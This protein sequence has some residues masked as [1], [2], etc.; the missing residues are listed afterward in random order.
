MATDPPIC[1]GARPS[2]LGTAAGPPNI[3]EDEDEEDVV[4]V[5]E[6]VVLD[7]EEVE[8]GKSRLRCGRRRRSCLLS[9]FR[10]I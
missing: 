5:V 4:F 6:E 2:C 10:D 7:D 8:D 3:D 9:P 1:L